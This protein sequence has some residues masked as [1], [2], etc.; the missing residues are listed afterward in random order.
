M[1]KFLQKKLKEQK[2]MTLIEL[3]AVIVIIAIIAAIAIPA[4]GGIIENSRVGAIKADAIN[5][6]NAAKIYQADTN[7]TTVTLTTLES[8]GYIDDAGTFEN[9]SAADKLNVKV[10]FTG[11]NALLSGNNAD[12]GIVLTFSTA[13]I[14]S[15]NGLPNGTPQGGTSTPAG[16]TVTKR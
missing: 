4:I 7:G 13:S 2:G 15:I 6:I 3:L 14:A 5:V 8:Q 11:G 9:L 12:D 16:V 10:D 1:K